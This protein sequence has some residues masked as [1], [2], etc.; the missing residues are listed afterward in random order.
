MVLTAKPEPSAEGVR[1]RQPGQIVGKGGLDQ[2]GQG[3]HRNTCAESRNREFSRLRP[4]GDYN[5]HD[6]WCCKYTYRFLILTRAGKSRKKMNQVVGCGRFRRALCCFATQ[7]LA[8]NRRWLTKLTI[9]ISSKSKWKWQKA[10][11]QALTF[12]RKG[13]KHLERKQKAQHD[14]LYGV[15]LSLKFK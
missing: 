7:R 4:A 14:F 13:D 8:T 11:E 15:G 10:A 9:E 5:T 12:L 6:G 3:L 2:A 1:N